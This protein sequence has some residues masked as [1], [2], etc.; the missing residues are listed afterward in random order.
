MSLILAIDDS[1]STLKV[2]TDQL[3]KFGHSTITATTGEEGIALARNN[4]PDLIILDLI[5]P[6]MDGFEILEA[7]KRK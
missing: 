2:L 3:K 5:L 1:I 4:F 7:L 6:V